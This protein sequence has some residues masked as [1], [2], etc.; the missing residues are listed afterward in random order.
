[1]L[2][3]QPLGE[4]TTEWLSMSLVN[5]WTIK[6]VH[7]PTER[8]DLIHQPIMHCYCWSR[9]ATLGF[10]SAYL[11]YLII[12]GPV[13]STEKTCDCKLSKADLSQNEVDE[14]IPPYQQCLDE[15]D[16][17]WTV[18]IEKLPRSY[19]LQTMLDSEYLYIRG[20][21]LDNKQNHLQGDHSYNILRDILYVTAFQHVGRCQR[22]LYLH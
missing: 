14:Q 17:S 18:E 4:A 15:D 21:H 11:I 10:F 19:G 16:R 13:R 22:S 6:E 2:A 9:G 8:T 20:N 12:R 5:D 1:M 3:S 7:G